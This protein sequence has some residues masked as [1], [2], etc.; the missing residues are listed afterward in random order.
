MGLIRRGFQ[1][2]IVFLITL[3][4]PLVLTGIWAREQVFDEDQFV[5]S[6]DSV[7]ADPN[8]QQAIAIR[9]SAAVEEQVGSA[10]WESF[11]D[12]VAIDDAAK[13]E[14]LGV[15]SE[16]GP[17]IEDQ[18]DDVLSSPAFEAVWVAIVREIHP[19]VT[20][21]LKGEDTELTQTT[22]GTITLDLGPIY[23]QL[24]SQLAQRGLDLSRIVDLNPDNLQLTVY[25]GDELIRAQESVRLYNDLLPVAILALIV[26]ELVLILIARSKVRAIAATGFALL[27]G[28][29]IEILALI[30]AR[31]VLVNAAASDVD[32]RAA[33]AVFT[34]FVG[35]LWRW[36]II[37]L[38]VG[39]GLLV[40]SMILMVIR[41]S[42]PKDVYIR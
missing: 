39:A 5:E 17:F 21:V 31:S 18:V 24:A 3:L 19:L 40:G 11:V 37:G 15:D 27:V 25:Q 33:K 9:L 22:N 1:I 8:V 36:A 16:I 29:G 34:E 2:L 28:M 42:R 41:G 23:E 14:F 6:M 4:I 38:V 7:Y 12:R 13:S 10:D 26:L 35:V 30:L 32:E 20:Q